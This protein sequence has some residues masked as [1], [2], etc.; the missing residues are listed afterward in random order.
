MQVFAIC[1]FFTEKLREQF[2][3]IGPVHRLGLADRRAFARAR[4]LFMLDGARDLS[5]SCSLCPR[6]SDGQARAPLELKPTAPYR[7]VRLGCHAARRL[8]LGKARAGRH[9]VFQKAEAG[10][11]HHSAGGAG[12]E[13]AAGD[14]ALARRAH[15]DR[16]LCRY[17]V[18]QR[19]FEFPCD[20]GVHE[21][22]S[23][24]FQPHPH[25]AARRVE[26]ALRLSARPRVHDADAV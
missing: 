21:R 10:Y 23:G 17:R 4:R 9:A 2:S 18:L 7:L 8:R 26:G 24:A 3:G 12:V 25:L 6:R 5:R 1:I 16:A 22:R 14:A 19:P 15:H 20:D 11:G 13:S